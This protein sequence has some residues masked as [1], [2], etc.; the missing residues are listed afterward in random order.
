[1]LYEYR[2]CPAESAGAAVHERVP[3][4]VNPG[5]FSG[6][7]YGSGGIE[8]PLSTSLSVQHQVQ[9]QIEGQATPNEM[10]TPLPTSIEIRPWNKQY[11]QHL[12][13]RHRCMF[14]SYTVTDRS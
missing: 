1:M 7:F 9:E 10:D 4:D 8:R 3:T 6:R 13:S 14:M 2:T 12:R 5:V 11:G